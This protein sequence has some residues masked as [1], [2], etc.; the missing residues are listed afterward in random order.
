M[1]L[2]TSR[3]HG[4][5]ETHCSNGASHD[6]ITV[7][8][9][10]PFSNGDVSLIPSALQSPTR[11]CVD[12]TFNSAV[13]S[14]NASFAGS[15]SGGPSTPATTA[16][17]VTGGGSDAAEAPVVKVDIKPAIIGYFGNAF[18]NG[19]CAFYSQVFLAKGFKAFEIGLLVAVSPL[20]CMTLLPTL[21]YLADKFRCETQM[22][23]GAIAITSAAMIG[24]TAAHAR[25]LVIIFFLTMTAARTVMGPLLDQRTLMMFPR[26]GRSIAWSYVRSYAAYGWGIGCFV[27]SLIFYMT[28]T[29]VTVAVQY[30]VGQWGLIYC[31]LVAKPYENIEKVPVRFKEVLHLLA[32]NKRV[33]LFLFASTMMGTGYSFIDNFLFLFLKELGGPEVL[34]GMTVVL[35]VSTEIPLFQKSERLHQMLTERHMMTIAM[36]VWTLRV[37]GYSLLQNP[38]W[39]LLIEPLHGVTFAF[40]WLPSVHLIARAFPPKLSSSATGVLF[41]FTSGVGPMIGNLVAGTLYSWVGPRK[42]FLCAATAMFLSLVFYLAMD[43]MLERR[44]VPIV[45]D[46][47]AAD[48]VVATEV[49]VTSAA[50]AGKRTNEPDKDGQKKRKPTS[51][52][53]GSERS[54]SCLQQECEGVAGGRQVAL[55]VVDDDL[56]YQGLRG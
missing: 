49:T 20:L 27:S 17:S 54:A 35:T 11:S 31:M 52:S 13:F 30:F 37:V 34:M 8:A 46:Y 26:E 3:S 55:D 7:P 24:Y 51:L 10:Q 4:A 23:L 38:W 14:R 43:Y 40:M 21:S 5:S 15:T 1:S 41:T 44:G 33:M 36:S 2:H 18:G 28:G 48:N 19:I 12:M 16:A 25:Y 47:D 56:P 22:M 39:V 53:D 45:C 50:E 42:M 29:W 9:L 32:S 6:T